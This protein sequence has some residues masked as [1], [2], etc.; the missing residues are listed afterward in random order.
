MTDGS[1]VRYTRDTAYDANDNVARVDVLNVDDQGTVQPN[2]HLTTTYE[3]DSLNRLVRRGEEVDAG[4]DVV[5]EYAYDANG[6]R[7]LVRFGEATNGNQP[8]NVVRTLYDERDLV[9]RVKR[10]AGDAA[11]SS[12]QHDYNANGNCIRRLVGLE[13]AP[14]VWLRQYDG[15]DRLAAATDPMGNV[16]AYQYD[17]NGNVVS[18]RIHGELVDAPGDAGNVLLWDT[19]YTYDGLDRRIDQAVAFFDPQ[20]Q[21]PIG[22]GWAELQTAYS[23]TSQVVRITDD[24]G[25]ARLFTYDTAN[26]QAVVTDPKGNTVT[27]AYD[28][29]S[30]VTVVA[31]T[32]TSDLGG[33][34]ETFDSWY[35][36]RAYTEGVL[37]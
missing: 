5:T 15:Y 10:G 27:Y 29:N 9:F 3:Y 20:T 31:R 8:A 13:D 35:V 1:G 16:T 14:R 11:Q 37:G 26:R 4:H 18:E 24:N 33:P 28:A 34:D 19:R 17:A 12:T 30:K 21:T 22:D 2:T 25:H 36:T 23:D 6:N 7:T 32:D